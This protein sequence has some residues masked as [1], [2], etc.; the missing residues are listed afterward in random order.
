MV[1]LPYGLPYGN[2]FNR[3]FIIPKRGI[4]VKGKREENRKKPGKKP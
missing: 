3:A 1:F 4:F 2:I